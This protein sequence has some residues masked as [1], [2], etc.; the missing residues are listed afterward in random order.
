[1]WKVVWNCFWTL[2]SIYLSWLLK[3]PISVSKELRTKSRNLE[4]GSSLE[5]STVTTLHLSC[6]SY[7]SLSSS[8]FCVL[9]ALCGIDYNLTAVHIFLKFCQIPQIVINNEWFSLKKIRNGRILNFT[10]RG[11]SWF[12]LVCRLKGGKISRAHLLQKNI[13]DI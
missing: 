12:G 7:P 11:Q 9:S 4:Q 1:M 2:Y 5:I 6:L 8:T 3:R 13:D 10:F